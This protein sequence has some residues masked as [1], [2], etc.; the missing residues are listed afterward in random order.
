LG[1]KAKYGWVLNRLL[2][3]GTEGE[4]WV[5][6]KQLLEFGTE[7]EVWVVFEQASG[8]WDRRRS[9]GGF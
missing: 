1:Q 3:F 6:F 2:E 7:G 9:M 4:V 5:V 8:V